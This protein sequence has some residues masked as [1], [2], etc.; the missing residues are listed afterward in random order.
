M[1]MTMMMTMMVLKRRGDGGAS[2][3]PQR[4]VATSRHKEKMI[5]FMRVL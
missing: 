3:L 5:D 1:L 4:D 2:F